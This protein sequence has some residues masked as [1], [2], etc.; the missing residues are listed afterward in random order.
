VTSVLIGAR[1]E[2]QL[3]DNLAAATWE[4]TGAEM[5][6]LDQASQ[7]PWP[8]P[9]SHHY[10]WGSDRNPELFPRPRPEE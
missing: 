3:R 4:L 2:E 9:V 7:K 5:E 1:T 8:Y 10:I 6:A